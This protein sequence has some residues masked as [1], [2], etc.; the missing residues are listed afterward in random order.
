[1]TKKK[2]PEPM[3]E[4]EQENEVSTSSEEEGSSEEEEEE[5]MVSPHPK[6]M[7][8]RSGKRKRRRSKET[9]GLTPPNT[10]NGKKRQKSAAKKHEDSDTEMENN[11]DNGKEV[12]Q[13]GSK[14]A[15]ASAQVAA[16]DD[17]DEEEEEEVAPAQQA[18]PLQKL[19][20][21]SQ[22]TPGNLRE[23]A[24]PAASL[25]EAPDLGRRLLFDAQP[26][27]G[28]EAAA[29]HQVEEEASPA[30]KEPQQRQADGE[31]HANGEASEAIPRE[32]GLPGFIRKLFGRKEQEP[33]SEVEVPGDE[34]SDDNLY[35][36]PSVT[37]PVGWFMIFFVLQMICY[38][39][40]IHPVLTTVVASSKRAL[41]FYKSYVPT[42]E[43]PEVIEMVPEVEDTEVETEVIVE[44]PKPSEFM[45]E[46][47]QALD[48][49]K[50]QLSALLNDIKGKSNALGG[51]IESIQTQIKG[52]ERK[53]EIRSNR[54]ADVQSVLG[55]AL[56][57]ND[58]QSS[59]WVDAREA[60][61]TLG[62]TMLD[63]SSF[64]LWQIDEPH[65]CS[66]DA[67]VSDDDDEE[68]DDTFVGTS[69]L[70]TP[71]MV[72]R[73]LNDLLLQARMAAAKIMSSSES[74]ERVRAWVR[75]NI[76]KAAQGDRNAVS[77]LKKRTATSSTGMGTE[78]IAELIQER[79]EME[80]ADGTG[81]FDF[82]SLLSGAKILMGSRRG[83]SRSLVDALP[84]LNRLMHLMSLR[85]YGFG[86]EAA[87]M[88]T[89]PAD[90]LGQCWAF[91]QVPLKEQIKRRRIVDNNSN[92]AGDDHKRGN[93][94]TLTISRGNYGTLTISLPDPVY[95]ESVVIEHPSK[96]ITE[97]VTTAIRSFRIIGYTDPEANEKAWTLGSFEYNINDKNPMQEF[98]VAT[99]IFG[100]PVPPL[101]SITLAIDSNWGFDYACLYRFRV[102]GTEAEEE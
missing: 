16:P 55:R 37:T 12:R 78:H 66:I 101:H 93:Y 96:D 4:E 30:A 15:V 83:T 54:L 11:N 68:E 36:H 14:A 52:L 86:P 89:Y 49:S 42:P 44:E 69:L 27:V 46:Q 65:E 77:M 91:E 24:R 59:V 40:T 32:G 47:L 26:P 95:V 81:R 17:D 13:N 41:V 50:Q 22:H 31:P 3:D 82:A 53:I 90:A 56:S 62:L 29:A 38:T 72:K 97:Q 28:G 39:I 80:R 25:A 6:D 73:Q 21:P 35:L 5:V 33:E 71:E 79:L 2:A 23:T 9:S 57:D 34:T 94:G 48:F 64:D 74:K 10:I 100:T 58:L 20:V 8:L 92:K 98:E 43:T 84:I 75:T 18:A 76:G 61:S 87:L 99:D 19:R 67:T 45:L 88:P 85:F 7:A 70:A 51:V 60:A 102:H 63:L 1:M